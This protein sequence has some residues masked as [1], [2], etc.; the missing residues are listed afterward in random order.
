[1]PTP[2]LALDPITYGP[3]GSRLQ[4]LVCRPA[5]FDG[6]MPG[7]L[8]APAAFGLSKHAR[9]RAQMLAG[10]GYVVLVADHY[11]EGATFNT[12]VEAMGPMGGLLADVPA[13]VGRL[14]SGLDALRALDGVDGDRVGAVGFCVGGTAVLELACAGADL[15][16]AVTFHGGLQLSDIN[17]VTALTHSLLICTGGADPLV[18]GEAVAALQQGLQASA[19]DWQVVVYGNAKHAFTD[20]DIDSVAVPVA[21]Y[22]RHADQRSWAAMQALFAERLA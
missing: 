11:G 17:A 8:L 12:L 1:M 7:I 20:P 6:L 5:D 13:W 15:K 10:L 22:D 9:D 21:G 18:P 16:A 4:G 19:A 2:D 14:T 3:A